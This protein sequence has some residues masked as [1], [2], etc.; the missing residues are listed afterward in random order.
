M[1][2]GIPSL[3]QFNS[4]EDHLK[5]ASEYGFDFLEIALYYP[6]F[7]TDRLDVGKALELGKQYGVGFSFHV[8]EQNPFSYSRETRNAAFNTFEKIFGFSQALGVKTITMH[9]SDG[10]YSA[11]NGVKKYIDEVCIDEYMEYVDRFSDFCER[12]LDG[13]ETFVCIENT[14]GY[15]DFHKKAID[16]MLEKSC[17]G[18]TFDIGHSYKAGG[19][20]EKFIVSRFDRIQ[21]FHIHDVNEK[22][23]HFALGDG[24]LDI[25]KYLDMARQRDCSTVIEVKE[26]SSIVRSAEYLNANGF[27]KRAS[28]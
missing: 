6:W 8:D 22:A 5:L 25:A 12:N 4:L 23:N 11:V 1:R 2:F 9:L 17:F 7:Q 18:L 13:S 15:K 10:V 16:H 24:V 14:H 20:D 26:A 28:R 21:H 3:L 19:L 27:L